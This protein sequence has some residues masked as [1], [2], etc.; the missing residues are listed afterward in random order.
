M[1]LKIGLQ[2]M[3]PSKCI[4]SVGKDL[5]NVQSYDQRMISLQKYHVFRFSSNL[6]IFYIDFR[7]A[8]SQATEIMF[9][10]QLSAVKSLGGRS[11]I[12]GFVT[13]RPHQF[14]RNALLFLLPDKQSSKPDI[15]NTSRV[16]NIHSTCT[17]SERCISNSK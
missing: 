4:V 7:N 2:A 6:T 5:S 1:E 10:L 3:P 8:E 9:E 14:R 13:Y 12:E 16:I 17:C 15:R 11:V